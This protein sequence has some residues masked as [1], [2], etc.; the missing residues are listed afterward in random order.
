M[1]EP[2][3]PPLDLVPLGASH[4]QRVQFGN[5]CSVSKRESFDLQLSHRLEKQIT[6]LE[7]PEGRRALCCH[8]CLLAWEH[9]VSPG[10]NLEIWNP[11]KGHKEHVE[12][13]FCLFSLGSS[14]W[15]LLRC[16]LW[17]DQ[18]DPFCWVEGL[19]WSLKRKLLRGCFIKKF[20]KMKLRWF[21]LRAF[22]KAWS[23]LFKH[24]F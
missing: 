4:H 1:T 16:L 12:L 21:S 6:G 2:S 11:E 23:N 15:K 3:L 5:Q 20:R 22:F 10:V 7:I 9:H 8:P 17:G 14:V 24:W 19:N 13:M 18:E